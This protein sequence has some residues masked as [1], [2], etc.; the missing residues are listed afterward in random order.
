MT[1][2]VPDEMPAPRLRPGS[3]LGYAH[4]HQG[5]PFVPAACHTTRRLS[6]VDRAHDRPLRHLQTRNQPVN[7][8]HFPQWRSWL[9]FHVLLQVISVHARNKCSFNRAT[10]WESIVAFSTALTS[11]RGFE[12]G[13]AA[14]SC[15]DVLF[16]F[17]ASTCVSVAHAESLLLS[18]CGSVI[19]SLA[20]AAMFALNAW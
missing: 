1:V 9:L 4:S 3:S 13:V 10:V 5:R 12:L 17:A 7:S 8:E 20:A 18:L 2:K 19:L 11:G 14:L 15:S 6:G 16:A